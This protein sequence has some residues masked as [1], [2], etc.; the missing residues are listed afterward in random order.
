MKENN[1]GTIS[2]AFAKHYSEVGKLLAAKIEEKGN[3]KNPMQNMFNRVE[4]NC[5]LFPTRKL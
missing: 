2:N 4:R 5:F 3:V 1:A